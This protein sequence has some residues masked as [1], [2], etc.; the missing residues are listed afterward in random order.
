M[1][2]RLSFVRVPFCRLNVVVGT[3][4]VKF[5]GALILALLTFLNEG[6][7]ILAHYSFEHLVFSKLS[8]FSFEN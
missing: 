6:F 4:N 8:I 1:P 2:T 3:A 7:T 5:N